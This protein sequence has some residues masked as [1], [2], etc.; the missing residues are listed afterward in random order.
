MDGRPLCEPAPGSEPWRAA[1]DQGN[2]AAHCWEFDYATSV[3][4]LGR[5]LVWHHSRRKLHSCLEVE[6]TVCT[7]NSS[8]ETEFYQAPANLTEVG[9]G[10]KSL[11]MFFPT[12]VFQI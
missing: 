7:F 5:C 11:E 9:D 12:N 8:R 4:R 1:I 10:P 3:S 6:L 2:P